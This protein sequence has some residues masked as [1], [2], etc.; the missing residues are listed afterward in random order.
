MSASVSTGLTKVA[1]RLET[2]RKISLVGDVS[3]FNYFDGSADIDI[4]ANATLITNTEIEEML[5]NG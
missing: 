3:G 5:S 4:P 1:K 2:P